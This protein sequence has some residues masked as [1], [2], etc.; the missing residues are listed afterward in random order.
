[1]TAATEQPQGE[2]GIRTNGGEPF[3]NVDDVAAL[4]G[5]A[6]KTVYGWVYAKTIPHVKFGRSVLRFRLSDIE[7]WAE[8][9]AVAVGSDGPRGGQDAA[10]NAADQ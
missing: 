9:R 1:M 6:R 7:A 3:M 8:S 2:K 10:G 4:L 5:V